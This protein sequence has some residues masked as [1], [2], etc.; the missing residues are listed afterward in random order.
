MPRPTDFPTWGTDANFTSGPAAGSPVVQTPS[1]GERAQGFVPGTGFISE[2]ANYI[3]NRLSANVN[4][5]FQYAYGVDEEHY[6]ETPKLRRSV[7]PFSRNHCW[8]PFAAGDFWEYDGAKIVSQVND[9]CMVI[10]LRGIPAG[11]QIASINVRAKT[12][13]GAAGRGPF[14]RMEVIRYRYNA[15]LDLSNPLTY[16]SG[17][18]PGWEVYNNGFTPPGPWVMDFPHINLEFIAGPSQPFFLETGYEYA[19][20]VWSGTD[21]GGHQ[22]DEFYGVAVDWFDVGPRSGG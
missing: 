8:N 7:Y 12:K 13:N 9:A 1:A 18:N 4:Y 3:L 2:F 19:L 10:A 17:A 22:S 14:A 21:A 20:R 16:D 15:V 11:A 5:L 6:Y